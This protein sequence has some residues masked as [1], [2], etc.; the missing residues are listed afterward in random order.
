[1]STDHEPLSPRPSNT[2]EDVAPSPMPDTIEPLAGEPGIPDIAQ[3]SRPAL[4]RKAL[5]AG[6][7]LIASI[8]SMLGMSIHRFTASAPADP[9]SKKRPAQRPSAAATEA[10]RLDL[11][12]PAPP[13]QAGERIPALVPS[14]EERAAPIGLQ[15]GSRDATR[16]S[17]EDAPV[18]LLSG[19][20][21]VRDAKGPGEEGTAG[22]RDTSRSLQDAQRQ[23]H[24]LLDN[25]LR[26][27]EAAAASAGA[28]SLS[29][30]TQEGLAG[31]AGTTATS[32]GAAALFG[33]AMPKSS[34]PH[35]DATR[36]APR[37]L[38]LPKGTSFTCALKSR[39]VSA[40]AGLVG[41][42]VQRNVYSEDG[43]VLLVERGSHLDG[44]Y[45]VTAIKPGTVRIPLLW[46]RLRTPLGISVDLD[47]PGTGPL[48]ESGV[49]GHVDNRWGERIGAAMLLSLIDDA[50]RISVANQTGKQTDGV[51]M[52]S[53]TDTGSDLAAKVLDSTIGIPPVITQHQ[54]AIVGVHVA[55]DVDFTSVYELIP[56]ERLGQGKVP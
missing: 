1:M 7:V 30:G 6:V 44:E 37:S 20:S 41:C 5:I 24:Q 56:N 17:P 26:R 53:T 23:T 38:V 22:S 8:V 13:M 16:T 28:T 29:G 48:G 12:I 47:S 10:K 4:S 18:M 9:A 2:I 33:G 27:S 21:P 39:I 42:Q 46:T 49:D 14:A 55:R 45:R 43:R 15:G 52:S 19:K 36:L 50:V 31:R 32:A 35:T 51:V 11:S 54:G 25:L 40:T 34:T 3:R